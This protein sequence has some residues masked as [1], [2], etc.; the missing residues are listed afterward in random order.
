MVLKLPW[1]QKQMYYWTFEKGNFQVFAHF[2]GMKLKPLT[3][4]A[5]QSVQKFL[6]PKLVMVTISENGFEATR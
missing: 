4:K 5:R 6:D 3:V 1:G 2:R